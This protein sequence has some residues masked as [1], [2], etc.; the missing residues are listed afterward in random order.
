MIRRLALPIIAA[1]AIGLGGFALGGG[2]ASDPAPPRASPTIDSLL[3]APDPHIGLGKLLDGCDGAPVAKRGQIVLNTS[4]LDQ[5][6]REFCIEGLTRKQT[7]QL[8]ELFTDQIM[9]WTKTGQR[10]GERLGQGT[11][12]GRWKRD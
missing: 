3:A 6:R 2:F 12:A 7:G 5:G 1:G 11:I 9:G 4:Y 10:R 8:A